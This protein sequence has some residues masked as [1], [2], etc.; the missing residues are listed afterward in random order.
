MN[1]DVVIE[2]WYAIRLPSFLCDDLLM[3]F[4]R[5]DKNISLFVVQL[6]KKII[7]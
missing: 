2:S 4:H 7:H 6:D 1:S 5:I 3:K